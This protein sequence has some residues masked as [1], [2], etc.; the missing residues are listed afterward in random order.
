MNLM[1]VT[2]LT[3]M[4]FTRSRN[5]GSYLYKHFGFHLK[6]NLMVASWSDKSETLN[7]SSSG[8]HHGQMGQ[9]DQ[10]RLQVKSIMVR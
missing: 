5:D 10:I 8:I 1:V 2:H 7:S 6:T 3:M 9:N 4:D